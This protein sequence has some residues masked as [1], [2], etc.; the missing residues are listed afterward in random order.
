MGHSTRRA[1][2]QA[3]TASRGMQPLMAPI[4]HR[5][6]PCKKSFAVYRVIQDT[7]V[8]FLSPFAL[9]LSALHFTEHFTLVPSVERCHATTFPLF[10]RVVCLYISLAAWLWSGSE[11]YS[12]IS[13]LAPIL[14]STSPGVPSFGSGDPLFNPSRV[15]GSLGRNPSFIHPSYFP[16]LTWRYIVFDFNRKVGR[17]CVCNEEGTGLTVEY[18]RF[19]GRV[20]ITLEGSNRLGS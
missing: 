17:D 6:S 18:E 1:S 10:S 7:F 11:E 20:K 3:P 14:V 16:E 13:S 4:P 8:R 19:V 5:P 12:S 9:R 15:L 2:S